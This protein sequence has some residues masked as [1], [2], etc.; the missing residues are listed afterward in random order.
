MQVHVALMPGEFPDVGLDGRVALVVDVFRATTM[1]VAAFGAGCARV[2]P[3][4]SPAA[5]REK[6]AAMAPEPVLLA[7][8]RGGDPIEGFDLG[9][10][11]LECTPERVG[12]RT[13]ILTT[14]NG[15]RAMLK[16]AE[17]A[18]AAV[19]ALTNASAAA[20]WA[21]ASGRDVTVLCAGEQGS[22]SLEDAACAGLLVDGLLRADPAARLSDAAQAAHCLGLAYG[23][24]PERLKSDAA[25]ARQLHRN[26][27]AADLDA[28]ARIDTSSLVPEI[29][30][31]AVTL[32][33]DSLTWAAGAP[34]TRTGRALGPGANR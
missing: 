28:C 11:P 4:A 32:K 16:A 9:N 6:A 34:D 23:G 18:A 21:A 31:G 19:A 33:G 15:T 27:R 3:V 20:R 13:L 7:G 25:W 30:A 29:S 10:S 26:G 24:Q 17:A 2:I 22:F 5:A 8:E 14:T 1:V 12:G